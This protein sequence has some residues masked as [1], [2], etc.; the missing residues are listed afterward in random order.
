MD[1]CIHLVSILFKRGII[2]KIGNW[3][4]K[5][6][7]CQEVDFQLRGL[8]IGGNYDY[9]SLNTGLMRVHDGPKN[10]STVIPEDI[11]YFFRKWEDILTP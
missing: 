9:F 11:I 5:L 4:I 7:R 3:D 10:M 6:K 1:G 8:L 2:N